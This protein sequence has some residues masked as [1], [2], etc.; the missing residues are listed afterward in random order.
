[1]KI[2]KGNPIY[3]RLVDFIRTDWQ[4]NRSVVDD[5]LLINNNRIIYMGVATFLVH[6]LFVIAFNLGY[7]PADDNEY[8]WRRGIILIH[9]LNAAAVLA[10][11]A[12][13]IV[14]FRKKTAFRSMMIVENIYIADLL[15][16]GIA[17]VAVD[18]HVTSNIT[19]FLIVCTIIGFFIVKRPINSILIFT[20]AYIAF[21]NLIGLYQAD[22]AILMSN[23]ANGFTFCSIG[24]CL[25]LIIWY[26]YRTNIM[27]DRKI[28]EQ[29]EEL[30]QLA[31]FDNLTGLL[32]RRR[33][34][35]IL[36]DEIERMNRYGLE[37]GL[38]LMDIDH[39]KAVNDKFG[40]PVGD[41]VLEEIAY[42]LK[43]ELRITD[44][45]ARWGGE[46][47]I[48]LLPETSVPNSMASAEKIRKSIEEMQIRVDD[49]VIK[50]TASFGV[51]RIMRRED[52]AVS[53]NRAD[54]AL[55]LAK[56]MGRNLVKSMESYNLRDT[57]TDDQTTA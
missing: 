25:S 2:E 35:A 57:V 54:E 9:S 23:R 4:T 17:V 47:F 53:Y 28:K 32:N 33:W 48:I 41:K 16:A 50:V 40:H 30:K 12:A 56:R 26:S 5:M 31:F 8:V 43:K 34:M 6:C 55:Y 36:K 52:F 3:T 46:E 20:G 44:K 21:H 24:L 49:T 42:I 45:V 18:Q 1:M 29:Q 38:I 22:A 13:S 7:V 19:P 11:T 15:I 14:L 27:Q 10:I 37:C 51:A 39:F